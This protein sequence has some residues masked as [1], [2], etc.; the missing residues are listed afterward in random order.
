MP[1]TRRDFLTQASLLALAPTVPV[2][3]AR[4][5]RAAAPEKDGRVL[6]VIQLDGGNDGINTVVPFK[7]DG[8]AKFR[9]ALR[10]P[11]DRLH[12]ITKEVGLHPSMGDA[13]K[14]VEK[15]WLAVVQGVGY[16][17]PSRSHF[18]SMAIWH[19]ADVSLPKQDS[20]DAQ[21]MA[22][23]GWIGQALDVGRRPP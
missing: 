20:N 1:M 16:P 18:K 19:T 15:G 17:N 9:K 8:Y 4:T 14:L 7:D 10:L 5:A 3:L 22:S 2:F 13:A 23:L 6:V 21:T 12:K 11:A